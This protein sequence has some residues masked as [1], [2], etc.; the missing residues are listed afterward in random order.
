MDPVE[1]AQRDGADGATVPTS[2]YDVRPDRPAVVSAV[3]L[4]AVVTAAAMFAH[5]YRDSLHW[6]V[7]LYSDASTTTGAASRLPRLVVF[8][9]VATTVALAATVGWF[10]ERRFS[11]RTGVEAFAASARGEERRISVR[12]TAWRAAATWVVSSALV[13]IGRESAIIEAGGAF[14]TIAGRRARGRGDT[15]AAAGIAAAFAGAYHAP[16]AAFVYVEEHL[17][18]RRSRRALW[19]VILGAIGGHLVAATWLGGQAIFPPIQGSRW[20]VLRLGLVVLVPAALTARL[21]LA[22]RTHITIRAIIRRTGARP[23][24]VIAIMSVIAGG[25]VAIYPFA[26]GNGMDALRGASISSTVA[27]ALALSVGKL[28]GTTSAL[29]AGAPGGVLTP[30]IT[31][32]AGFGLLTLLAVDGLGL[33]VS[34]PWNG[35]VAAMA[36]GFTVGLRS[37]VGAI[38]LIP[39]LVGD[40]RL[41]PVIAMVVAP[42]WLLDRALDR[43]LGHFGAG[44]P[45]RAYDRV[46]DA[47]A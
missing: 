34:H 12:A 29:G 44:V 25:C 32:S 38:F 2:G 3:L 42:A 8:A 15:L 45:D 27:L 47:D 40:Y 20:S 24:L 13:S 11:G 1:P 37:P 28:I 26:A 19:F 22:M 18:V 33:D 30:T 31:V 46:Y 4:V 16:I 14:G 43:A 7:E 39:E 23:W 6:A 41:V 36:V 9:L 5:Y 21:L 10:V 17:G 35:M